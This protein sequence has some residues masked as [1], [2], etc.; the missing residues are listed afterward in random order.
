MVSIKIQLE[1]IYITI[2]E[3][4]T[5]KTIQV[6]YNLIGGRE[7]D[8][9][10]LIISITQDAFTVSIIPYHLLGKKVATQKVEEHSKHSNYQKRFYKIPAFMA[11]SSTVITGVF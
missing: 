6:S 2:L 4:V 10:V 9:T 7:K 5:W 11:L 3:Y 8:S 1:N